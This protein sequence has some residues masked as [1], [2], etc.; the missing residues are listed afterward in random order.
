MATTSFEPI[1]I[2]RKSLFLLPSSAYETA[3][4]Q[5]RV[6]TYVCACA[7]L[8]ATTSQAHRYINRNVDKLARTCI[9]T[10]LLARACSSVF[11]LHEAGGT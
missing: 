9:T 11:C 10:I 2:A 7:Y 8:G 6:H 5:T 1:C 3:Y 4:T